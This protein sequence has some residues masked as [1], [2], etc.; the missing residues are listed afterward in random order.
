[1]SPSFFNL[2]DVLLNLLLFKQKEVHVISKTSI[3]A[4]ACFTL[5]YRVF[6]NGKAS[7]FLVDSGN[8]VA[9]YDARVSFGRKFYPSMRQYHLA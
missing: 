5:I 1:M 2:L 7:H 9:G 3:L 4:R 8:S 6:A